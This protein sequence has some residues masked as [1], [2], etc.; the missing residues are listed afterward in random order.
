LLV[1]LTKEE[2]EQVV[3]AGME[4]EFDLLWDIKSVDVTVTDD[5]VAIDVTFEDDSIIDGRD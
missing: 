3:L 4:S 1:H 5:G 2:L